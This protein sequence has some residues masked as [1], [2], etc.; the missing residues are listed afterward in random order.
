MITPSVAGHKLTAEQRIAAF[1]WSTISPPVMAALGRGGITR[2]ADRILPFT[3]LSGPRLCGLMYA[4]RLIGGADSADT[5]EIGCNAGGASRLMALLNGG[6]RHWACDTFCGLV[7]CGPIDTDLADGDFTNRLAKAD[8]VA[9]RLADLPHVKVVAGVMPAD[10]PEEM[11]AA[12]FALAHIDV[13]TYRSML[14]CFDFVAAR[15]VPGGII[16]L[17]DVLD[18]GTAGGKAAWQD[19]RLRFSSRFDVLARNTQQIV[20]QFN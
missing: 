4:L 11:R 9:A 16:V 19:I 14:A 20:L 10:A 17:D 7:D 5:I 13:D 15:M 8:G 18:G 6:R 12:R 3:V 1:D 2:E